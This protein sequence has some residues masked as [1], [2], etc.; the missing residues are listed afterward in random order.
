MDDIY[1]D[2]F[3]NTW[4]RV[5]NAIF[6]QQFRRSLAYNLKITPSDERLPCSWQEEGDGVA[7]YFGVTSEKHFRFELIQ[8]LGM[9]Q[10]RQPG[11]GYSMGIRHSEIDP[12]SAAKR[13]AFTLVVDA[14]QAA[15]QWKSTKKLKWSEVGF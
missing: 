11:G 2:E 9:V 5:S 13:M 3:R 1:R 14:T 4:T 7:I 8:S 10:I 12:M 15:R 6:L